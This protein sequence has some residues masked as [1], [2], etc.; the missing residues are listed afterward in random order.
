[1][2]AGWLYTADYYYESG[3]SKIL[4][5][6]YEQLMLDSTRTFTQGDIY[7]FKRWYK[8]QEKEV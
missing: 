1:M 5:A 2:D 8:E 4:T 3:V 7:Y 6:V